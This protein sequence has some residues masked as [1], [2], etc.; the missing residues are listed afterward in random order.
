[1]KS[2]YSIV[3]LP[4]CFALQAQTTTTFESFGLSEGMFLNGSTLSDSDEGF[5]T[6]NALLINNY[7]LG[8]GY[9][10]WEGWAISATTDVTTPGFTNEYSSITGG[11]Y[12]G[13]T[14][15]AT[16]Y[17]FNPGKIKLRGDAAGK[18]VA[19]LYITNSTYAYLSMRD[20]S[21]PPGKKF[22]GEDGSDPDFLLLTI[23]GYYDGDLKP[24]SVDFYLADYRFDNNNQDYIIDEWTYVDLTGLGNVDS[25]IFSLSSSDTGQF[26][27]NTPTYFCIDQFI[28]TDLMTNVEEADN[29]PFVKLSPN[30]ATSVLNIDIP[31]PSDDYNWEIFSNQG[32]RLRTGLLTNSTNRIDISTLPAGM[33]YLQVTADTAKLVRSFIKQ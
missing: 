27:I 11:G 1:M 15:Y 16:S 21:S 4:F 9:D 7:T 24:Q 20:G 13:S 28:T 31:Q 23:Q 10:F 18:V 22:G 32:Q 30:P 2:L 8:N 26:G 14:T 29:T 33:Y 17:A 3:L 5:E 25:L 19:G 12:D 6:E